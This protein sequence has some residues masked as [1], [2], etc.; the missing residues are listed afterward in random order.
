MDRFRESVRDILSF[1]KT[2]STYMR[3]LRRE[4]KEKKL[5]NTRC[6]ATLFSS[7][8]PTEFLKSLASSF[9]PPQLF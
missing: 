1:D 2:L 8:P 7:R 4:R 6:F 5:S 9:H 3:F